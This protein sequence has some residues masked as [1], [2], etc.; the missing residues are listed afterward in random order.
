MNIKIRNKKHGNQTNEKEEKKT[1]VGEQIKTKQD[2]KIYI[3]SHPTHYKPN[4]Y[5]TPL[6]TQRHISNRTQIHEKHLK[7]EINRTVTQSSITL[8]KTEISHPPPTQR[9]IS[10]QTLAIPWGGGEGPNSTHFPATEGPHI[11]IMTR[12][13]CRAHSPLGNQVSPFTS[14]LGFN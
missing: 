6:P 3:Y 2:K 5:P 8:Q 7:K 12:V 4:E 10:N 13:S 1:H 11:V 14:V 9:R